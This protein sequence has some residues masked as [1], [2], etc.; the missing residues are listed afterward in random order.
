MK[1]IKKMFTSWRILLLLFVLIISL[2]LLFPDPT[3]DG[4]AIRNVEKNSSAHIAGLNSPPPEL[5]P[6]F[7]EVITEVDGTIINNV[8]DYFNVISNLKINDSITIKTT[9]R[10]DYQT[11]KKSFFKKTKT[12]RNII[13]QPEYNITILNETEE[14]K[15]NETILVN[16]T[17]NDTIT[18]INK[19]R[20]VIKEVPKEL[21]EI[22]GA[23][24]IGIDVY[25]APKTNLK[26]GLDLQ[27][28]T[29]V[30]LEPDEEIDSDD[31]DLITSNLQ[32]RLNVFGLSDI[33][34]RPVQRGLFD[35]TL[36]MVEIAGA[37]EDEVRHL[38]SGQGKF[39]AKINDEV[40]FT[41]GDDLVS[42]CRTPECSSATDPSRPPAKI[43]EEEWGSSFYFTVKLSQEAA[44]R[45]AQATQNLDVIIENDNEYLS[46]KLLLY[47]DD[48]LVNELFIGGDMRGK[49]TQNIQI[50]GSGSGA[51]RQEA[52]TDSANN[53]KNLQTLLITGSLPVKLNIVKT[54]SI[55]PILGEQ[56]TKNALLVGLAAILA[57]SIFIFIRY[58]RLKLS[59]PLLITILAEVIIILGIASGIGWN[60][61]LAAI[62]GIII[63]IGTGIDHQIIIIDEALKSKRKNLAWNESLKRA[64]FIIFAAFFT[65]VTAMFVLFVSGAGLFR[66]F[67][68]TTIIG[69]VVGVLIS[70]PAFAKI[71][72]IL[73]KDES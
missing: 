43:S 57:V 26:K 15:V 49:P 7:R 50:S 62:A 46:E 30:L 66:G 25:N 36:I 72:E 6:M 41:G 54:D 65:T 63:A 48:E 17:I 37:H 68:L 21:K 61:D 69:V 1:K 16:E 45:V 22:I 34:I 32:Q 44:N 59:I 38:I 56:F 42:V 51:T 14:I 27:G 4:V 28:G 60:L 11:N 64:F 71:I 18:E 31:I 55:S 58:R 23:E 3:N 39:E 10:Y 29:R 73:F 2:I 12:Y 53:M 9:S 52:I 24:A 67:A 70:R 35:K 47:L 40:V 13:V 33:V 8:D 5:K 20:E 19:T